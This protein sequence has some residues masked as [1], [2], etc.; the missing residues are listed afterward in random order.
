MNKYRTVEDTRFGCRYVHFIKEI[1]SLGGIRTGF[2]PE[3]FEWG[4]G[5][6]GGGVC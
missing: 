3:M 6:R 1:I 2:D 4:G 5:G